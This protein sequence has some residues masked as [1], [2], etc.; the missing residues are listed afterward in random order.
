MLAFLDNIKGS[1][2]SK[3]SFVFKWLILINIQLLLIN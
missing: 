2:V 3:A 1:F